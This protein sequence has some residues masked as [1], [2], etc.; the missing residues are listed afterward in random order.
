MPRRMFAYERAAIWE[1]LPRGLVWKFWRWLGTPA[2]VTRYVPPAVFQ[3]LAAHGA[4]SVVVAKT[5]PKQSH[6]P[7]VTVP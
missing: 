4:F 1:P 2:A 3:V 6:K 7:L 5:P